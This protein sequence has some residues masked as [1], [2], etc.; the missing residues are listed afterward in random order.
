[1][2]SLCALHCRGWR[3]QRHHKHAQLLLPYQTFQAT[4]EHHG[5]G[6]ESQQPSCSAG[7]LSERQK[8]A[9]T[10]KSMTK[11]APA[12][13]AL[14]NAAVCR[15]AALLVLLLGDGSERR[16]LRHSLRRSLGGRPPTRRGARVASVP[17][18]SRRRLRGH[19]EEWKI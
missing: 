9:N 3:A 7:D 19:L 4:A 18:A 17:A 14:T 6:L 8:E 11:H 16:S 10:G 1:M 15:G 2:Q 13:G 5:S 12:P